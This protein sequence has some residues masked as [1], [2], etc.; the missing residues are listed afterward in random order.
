MFFSRVGF[1]E[2]SVYLFRFFEHTSTTSY[3]FVNDVL[4]IPKMNIEHP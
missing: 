1:L 4:N 2:L 3:D